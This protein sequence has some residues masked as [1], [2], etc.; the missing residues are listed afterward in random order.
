MRSF[1]T[2]AHLHG[3]HTLC[4]LK[5]TTKPARDIHSDTVSDRKQRHK[6]DMELK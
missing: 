6:A 4:I 2:V 1:F 5:P 3:S